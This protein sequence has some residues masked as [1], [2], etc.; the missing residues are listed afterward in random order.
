[1]KI[2]FATCVKLGL[3]CIEA[4]YDIGYSISLAISLPSHTA[5]NKSGRIF[6]DG[7]CKNKNIPLL[8]TNHIN[9]EIVYESLEKYNIDCLFIIGWSQ[10]ANRRIL[11]KSN[12]GSYGCHPT[13]LP[14]GRGRGSIPWTIIKGLTISGVTMFKLDEGVDTGPIVAQE[15]III[16]ERETASTLYKKVN[17][18]HIELIK[19]FLP[20]LYSNQ[21]KLIKQDEN[22]ATFW[23]GRKPEDGLLN[24]NGSI[25]DADKLIRATT[26]PYPGAF[27]IEKNKK[28]IIW[29]AKIQ[30][31]I[32]KDIQKSENII[33]F[34]D[35]ILEI[36]KDE[37]VDL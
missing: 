33:V 37:V 17:D 21:V 16:S 4:I 19:K 18:S 25:Y 31:D 30:K 24:L 11:N 10:I 20:V 27:Y 36:L 12:F 29:E 13:L 22:L 34:K 6:L 5:I 23:P 3:S 28:I 32:Q 2:A 26:K 1:M 35:G 9:D 14:V 7:F 15:K 8:K